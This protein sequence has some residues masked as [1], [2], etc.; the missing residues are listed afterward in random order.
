M[1]Q[2]MI[3]ILLIEISAHH[4]FAWAEELLADQDL[5]AGEGAAARLVGFIR[6]DEA[7]HVAYLATALTEMRD[8]TFVGES[9]RRILGT[10]VVGA[11]W[12]RGLADSLGPR[13]EQNLRVARRE[14]EDALDGRGHHEELLEQFDALADPGMRV[15]A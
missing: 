5:V 7:P 9:G 2:R 10:E 12:E 3:A 1:I 11:L 14:I 15:P 13:R 8:R 6:Q 4:A